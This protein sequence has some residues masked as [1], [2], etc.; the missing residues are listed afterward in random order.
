MPMSTKERSLRAN[1]VKTE[2]ARTRRFQR[3]VQEMREA[4]F[5]VHVRSEDADGNWFDV[6]EFTPWATSAAMYR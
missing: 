2:K 6:P 4:G 3:T 5:V 1:A